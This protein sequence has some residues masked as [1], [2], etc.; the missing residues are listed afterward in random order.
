MNMFMQLFALLEK[1]KM[2]FHQHFFLIFF[3]LLWDTNIEL[4][5][6]FWAVVSL[7]VISWPDF[8]KG[9]KMILVREKDTSY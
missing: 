8:N 2:K 6:I 3:F 7:F 9:G 5:N 1:N 4:C